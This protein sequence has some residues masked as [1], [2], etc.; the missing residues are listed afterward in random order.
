MQ[1]FRTSTCLAAAFALLSSAAALGQSDP[2]KPQSE[3][4]PA[5]PLPEF[6]SIFSRYRGYADQALDSWQDANQRVQQIGG[7]RAYAREIQQPAPVDR[8]PDRALPGA[9]K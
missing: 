9:G 7:W 6:V 8:P 3:A 5:P 1:F 2:A 4:A